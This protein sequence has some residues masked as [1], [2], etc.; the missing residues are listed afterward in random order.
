MTQKMSLETQIIQ[1]YKYKDMHIESLETEWY[2]FI[3]LKT[4]MHI[5]E[6]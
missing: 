6:V 2:N 5:S 1:P 3:C 4:W